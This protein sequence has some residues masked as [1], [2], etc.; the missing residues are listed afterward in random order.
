[1]P[2]SYSFL[3]NFFPIFV[4]IRGGTDFD[5]QNLSVH[6]E[7]SG[8]KSQKR[9][10]D[11]LH[12]DLNE[13]DEWFLVTLSRVILISMCHKIQNGTLK[14]TIEDDDGTFVCSTHLCTI[15]SLSAVHI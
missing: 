4:Y 12:D 11:I 13:G 1:M 3:N 5:D 14:M 10:I 2:H 9:I 15:W 7:T 8:V 6:F